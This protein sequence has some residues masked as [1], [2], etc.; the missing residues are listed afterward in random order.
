[1]RPTRFP[2]QCDAVQSDR[3]RA[4][5]A[6]VSHKPDFWPN[7]WYAPRKQTHGLP[8]FSHSGNTALRR[9]RN[10]N[11]QHTTCP[12]SRAMSEFGSLA[13]YAN[14]GISFLLLKW[15]AKHIFFRLFFLLVLHY[16]KP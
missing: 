8:S 13:D 11:Q 10:G 12:E 3:T 4:R 14:T 7:P 16:L 5:S 15:K 6:K 1:M 2:G 9:W